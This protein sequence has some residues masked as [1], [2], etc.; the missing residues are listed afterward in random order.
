MFSEK[1]GPHQNTKWKDDLSKVTQNTNTTRLLEQTSFK[2]LF[3]GGHRIKSAKSEKKQ[4]QSFRAK[5]WKP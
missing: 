4:F 3:E 1:I 2:L 5:V